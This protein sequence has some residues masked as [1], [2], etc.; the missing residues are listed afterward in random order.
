MA[1]RIDAE[2]EAGTITI[3]WHISRPVFRVC[4]PGDF[5]HPASPDCHGGK[6]EDRKMK[7]GEELELRALIGEDAARSIHDEELTV[8]R[9]ATVDDVEAVKLLM[10][11]TTL[12]TWTIPS[13]SGALDWTVSERIDT[14]NGGTYLYCACP[15]WKTRGLTCKHT[16]RV[17]F[18]DFTMANS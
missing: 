15:S 5:P 7:L 13:D 12:R 3:R 8:M 6:F 18:R 4:I 10:G 1:Y 2:Y 9:E 17:A 11:S 14:K 16:Q